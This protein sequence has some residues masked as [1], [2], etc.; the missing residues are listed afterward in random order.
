MIKCP[1]CQ[2]DVAESASS[3]P[4]CGCPVAKILAGAKKKA[5]LNEKKQEFIIMWRKVSLYVGCLAIVLSCV[6][7]Y[8]SVKFRNTDYSWA[9]WEKATNGGNEE[10]T[11]KAAAGSVT[12]SQYVED[13]KNT[14]AGNGILAVIFGCWAIWYGLKHRKTP[15][16]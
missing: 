3:C 13:E 14:L 11:R 6:A 15:I 5:E 7:F 8:T 10:L 1:E 12:Y 16:K 2:K 9:R 4:S